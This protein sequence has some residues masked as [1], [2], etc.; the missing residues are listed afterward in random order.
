MTAEPEALARLSD[1]AAAFAGT[2]EGDAVVTAVAALREALAVADDVLAAQPAASAAIRPEPAAPQAATPAVGEPEPYVVALAPTDPLA[3]REA[4][5]VTELTERHLLHNPDE[6]PE[7]RE[8]AAELR[9]PTIRTSVS[10]ALGPLATLDQQL[11]HVA[12]ANGI[13]IVP[14]SRVESAGRSDVTFVVVADV[15]ARVVSPRVRARW[16]RV[17]S[18]G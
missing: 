10:F 14:R 3:G 17:D 16:H 9:G 7:W 4:V 1:L 5:E 2:P 18:A 8:V 15:P 13:L 11:D 12:A 6:V